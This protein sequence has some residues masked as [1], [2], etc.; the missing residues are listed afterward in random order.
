MT[1]IVGR[2][3]AHL[4]QPWVAAR[5]IEV[6]A[7]VVSPIDFGLTQAAADSL[8]RNG[9][10]AARTFLDGWDP[11]PICWHHTVLSARALR[12]HPRPRYR[13][14]SAAVLRAGVRQRI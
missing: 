14:V 13:R 8:L 12:G 7:A 11:A 3:Q 10:A 1:A 2:D 4:A 6:D 9:Q 5:T